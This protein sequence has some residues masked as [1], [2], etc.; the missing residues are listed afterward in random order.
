M[1]KELEATTPKFNR[2]T[3]QRIPFPMGLAERGKEAAGTSFVVEVFNLRS[4]GHP[5]SLLTQRGI[6][7]AWSGHV[8]LVHLILTGPVRSNIGSVF[9][10]HGTD[11]SYW[12]G[13]L[14]NTSST[15]ICLPNYHIIGGRIG[16]HF[17]SSWLRFFAAIRRIH[18]CPI[19]IDRHFSRVLGIIQ[20]LVA[21]VCI[22]LPK[23]F[24]A[25]E[26]WYNSLQ[27][28]SRY[29]IIDDVVANLGL[30][31]GLPTRGRVAV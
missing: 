17:T 20:L 22:I 19:S 29:G 28:L 23:N 1:P 12:F 18:L 31:Q 11:P 10:W 13:I 27:K 25:K 26:A 24:H 8:G 3:L 6:E 5:S 7:A 9:N 4:G 14:S 16:S 30:I 15:N 2:M 21:K